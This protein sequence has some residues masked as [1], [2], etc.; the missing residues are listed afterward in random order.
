VKQQLQQARNSRKQD[1][2]DNKPMTVSKTRTTT[3]PRRATRPQRRQA[4]DGQQ[5]HNDD[6]PTTGN[7]TTTTTSPRRATRPQR[8]K[9]HDRQGHDRRQSRNDEKVTAP[10]QNQKAL[11]VIAVDK[12]NLSLKDGVR[13]VCAL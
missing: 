6:K 10:T 11:L 9:A 4:H 1:H 8:R 2:D 12:V 3:S 13:F 7:K 5:D